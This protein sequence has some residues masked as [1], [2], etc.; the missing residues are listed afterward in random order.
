M[1]A[2]LLCSLSLSFSWE[3]SQARREDERKRLL[4]VL[5]LLF[6]ACCVQKSFC[7]AAALERTALVAVLL[8]L[9]IFGEV[10]VTH[11]LLISKKKRRTKARSFGSSGKEEDV[12]SFITEAAVN[13]L[14]GG[15]CFFFTY[16]ACQLVGQRRKECVLWSVCGLPLVDSA[17]ESTTC[18]LQLICFLQQTCFGVH[19]GARQCGARRLPCVLTLHPYLKIIFLPLSLLRATLLRT[20][21]HQ[22]KRCSSRKKEKQSGHRIHIHTALFA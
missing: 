22:R 17:S 13:G 20:A 21:M 4:R 15:V 7:G 14:H 16:V 9:C 19:Y 5:S 18:A 1:R 12:R 2:L 6:C 8:L 11:T 3:T 10:G